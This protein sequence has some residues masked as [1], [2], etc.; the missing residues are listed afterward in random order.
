MGEAMQAECPTQA[1]QCMQNATHRR[2][3]APVATHRRQAVAPRLPP[4]WTLRGG[5]IE[6][7]P[8]Q[9]RHFIELPACSK[10]TTC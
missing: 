6:W 2:T 10:P 7:Q 4:G 8:I 3:G 9:N 1:K 5:T